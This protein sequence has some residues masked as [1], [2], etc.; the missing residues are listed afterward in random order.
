MSPDHT[1]DSPRMNAV[2]TI[3]FGAAFLLSLVA[4]VVLDMRGCDARAAEVPKA[5]LTAGQKAWVVECAKHPWPTGGSDQGLD[6]CVNN[7]RLL[8]ERGW[9]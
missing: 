2:A 4:V 7:A 3:T 6:R 5:P 9:L 1:P 8:G